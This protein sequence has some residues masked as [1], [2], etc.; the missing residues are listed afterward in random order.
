MFF[1]VASAVVSDTFPVTSRL[2]TKIILVTTAVVT[3]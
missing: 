3:E 2:A 1:L